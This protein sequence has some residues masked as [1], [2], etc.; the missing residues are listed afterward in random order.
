MLWRRWRSASG[1]VTPMTISSSQRG[2]IAP[3]VHHLRPLM[4]YSSPSRSMRVAMFVASDEATSGSVIENAERIV[5]SSS[6]SSQRCCCSAVPNSDSSSMLPVS[7][8]EQLMR[9]GRDPRV[10][11]RDLGQRRVLEVGQA[12]P[13]SWVRG[14]EQVPQPA[15]R[16][17]ALSSSS[18]GGI[19]RVLGRRRPPRG[20]APRRGTR[21]RP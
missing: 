17:S 4:T 10:A 11:A 14:Q 1:S 16:A 9:L 19:P 2:D 5:P 3:E 8:A 20:S 6:G 18:T 7:G 12:A 21:T 15:L 13:C